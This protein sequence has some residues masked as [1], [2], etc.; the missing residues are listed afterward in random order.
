M[1]RTPNSRHGS[2]VGPSQRQLRVAEEIRRA[3]SE[4]I[5]RAHFRDPEL[6]DA[7]ITISGARISP[8]LK[9]VTIF[10]AP[11]GGKR[12]EEIVA[13]LN[14]SR[15]YLRGELARAIDLRHVPE[16]R[17]ELDRSF[18]E[19]DHIGRLLKSKEVKRD[20]EPDSD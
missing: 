16:L 11:L 8:D 4:I 19:A 2:S 5:S 9:N 20:L 7:T 10:A 18:A 14:R 1:R 3:M 12:E 15:A 13:A 17:F 6:L